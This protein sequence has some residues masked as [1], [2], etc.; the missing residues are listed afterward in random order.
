MRAEAGL[1]FVNADHVRETI[2]ER[3][4]TK[5]RA[6]VLDCETSPVID[7]TATEM[8]AQLRRDLHREGITLLTRQIGQVGDVVR[9][10]GPTDPPY[11]FY[12]TIDATVAAARDTQPNLPGQQP[13][14]P[15]TASLSATTRAGSSAGRGGT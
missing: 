5:T 8:L 6:V 14:P 3:I 9:R 15:T 11:R 10:A 1:F 7:V 12:L 2:R 13:L 4:T